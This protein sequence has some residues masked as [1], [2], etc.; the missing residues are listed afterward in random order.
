MCIYMHLYIYIYICIS[1]INRDEK[2]CFLYKSK[3]RRLM[4]LDIHSHCFIIFFPQQNVARG[5]SLDVVFFQC[6]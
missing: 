1:G 5:F 4:S 2:D 6:L 3:T